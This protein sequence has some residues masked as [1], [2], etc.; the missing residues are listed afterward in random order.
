MIGHPATLGHSPDASAC[1][2]L[3]RVRLRM[4]RPPDRQI[5]MAEHGASG[6]SAA[7]SSGKV[8]RFRKVGY[9][10]RV[11]EIGTGSSYQVAILAEC[12]GCSLGW[13]MIVPLTG[14]GFATDRPEVGD[15][16]GRC[17]YGVSVARCSR[18]RGPWFSSRAA[19]RSNAR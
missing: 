19:S 6:W 12:R 9:G 4:P 7:P 13:A 3:R 11:F 18:D 10:S 8:A 14:R 15:H 2:S 16:A 17:P 5:V 1:S